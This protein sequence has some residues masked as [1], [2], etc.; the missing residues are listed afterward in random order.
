MHS[1]NDMM[2]FV[3][4][5]VMPGDSSVYKLMT[6]EILAPVSCIILFGEGRSDDSRDGGSNGEKPDSC[7]SIQSWWTIKGMFSF[8][9]F[10]PICLDGGTFNI[11]SCSPPKNW[12]RNFHFEQYFFRWAWF[13]HQ[14]VF[15]SLREKTRNAIDVDWGC[16]NSTKFRPRKSSAPLAG[17]NLWSLK[18]AHNSKKCL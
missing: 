9:S 13:N 17:K 11:F 15:S 8:L 7:H 12:G 2:W 16:P 4:F 1:E 14:A 5:D 6:D 10:Q 18:I 3:F